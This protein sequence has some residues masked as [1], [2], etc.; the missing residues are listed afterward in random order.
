MSL[1]TVTG[2]RVVYGPTVAVDGVD[3]TAYRGE[4]CALIG[5]NGAGKSTLLDAI[6]GVVPT[7]AGRVVLD[8]DDLTRLP[9][10]RRQRRGLARTFQTPAVLGPTPIAEVTLAA[11]PG[12]GV[13]SGLA[14]LPRH[15]ER[16]RAGELL[17]RVGLAPAQWSIPVDGLG[18][19]DQRRV[20]LARALAGNPCLVLLDEP[21]AGLATSE[22][23]AFADLL[24]ALP[25]PDLG[26]VL[27]EH[28][29]ALVATVAHVVVALDRGGV[30]ATGSYREVAADPAVRRSYLGDVRV[31]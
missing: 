9:P 1:L 7:A 4:V 10:H 20:E 31:G 27:V 29:M 25:G 15:S 30:V 18:L 3:L 24:L 28:D 13:L 16:A 17:E 6:A 14:R 5:P 22:R 8:G 23:A 2:V 26:I 21:A 19:V 11:M 12:R